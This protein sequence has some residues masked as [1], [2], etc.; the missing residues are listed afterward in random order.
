MRRHFLIK[1]GN[2]KILRVIG[3]FRDIMTQYNII[4]MR[5]RYITNYK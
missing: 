3:I 1:I 4:E 2:A 5:D